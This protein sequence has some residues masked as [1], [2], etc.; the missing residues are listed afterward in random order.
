MPKHELL[1]EYR[2]SN[3]RMT[4]A[5]TVP[6]GAI[7]PDLNTPFSRRDSLRPGPIT[8]AVTNHEG[9]LT[10]AD[11]MAFHSKIAM[12]GY[13]VYGEALH[14]RLKD[15]FDILPWARKSPAQV[16]SDMVTTD[17]SKALEGRGIIMLAVPSNA[18]PNVLDQI[19]PH[20]ESVVISFAKGL[21]VPDW[22][23]TSSERALREGPPE[24]ARA[25]TPLEYIREHPNWK[26]VKDNL[27]F[28][29]G[30]GFARDVKDGAYLGLTLGGMDKPNSGST[31]ALAKAFYV[32]SGMSGDKNLEI[33]P[34]P[35]ALEIAA[36]M[37]NVAAF[38]G[39][40]LLG[41]LKKNGALEIDNDGRF[42]ITKRVDISHGDHKASLDTHSLHRLVHFASR[43][44]VN[45]VKSE[46]GGKGGQ[47][48][49]A[50]NHDLNL[51]VNSLTSRNVQAGMRLACGENIYDI[52]TTRDED[53]HLLT[54]EGVFAA[55]AMAR[56]VQ[57]NIVQE[58]HAPLIFAVRNILMNRGTPESMMAL[59]FSQTKQW[60]ESDAQEILNGQS[61]PLGLRIHDGL[62]MGGSVN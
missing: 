37:K 21:I 46:G 25:Y 24:G 2:V 19:R 15:S 53:G 4:P 59:Y 38:A 36:S 30:P 33:Y 44:I 11:R 51:T 60:T 34:N 32:F 17:L 52:L 3:H 6:I 56:R 31:D 20:K 26:H 58:A 9:E 23:P 1:R 39:G 14:H 5:G 16:D 62:G 12:V 41:I 42:R 47:L 43:E 8:P 49:M 28:V 57:N 35:T 18:F 54:A 22:N 29:G 13:G 45:V 10:P 61:K 50:G 7:L 48:M 55:H 27:V 40:I